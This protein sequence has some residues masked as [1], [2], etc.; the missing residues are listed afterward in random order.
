MSQKLL[1]FMAICGFSCSGF[2]KS[3]LASFDV[4]LFV[5]VET[6]ITPQ[7]SFTDRGFSLNDASLK[8]ERSL[9][10]LKLSVDLPFSSN[11]TNTTDG[12]EF[13]TR[14]AEAYI[15]YKRG[16]YQLK[17]GQY[18][19]FFGYEANSSRERFFADWG[20]VREFALPKTHMG[21]QLEA[22]GASSKVLLQVANPNGN[23]TLGREGPEAGIGWW[24]ERGPL[25][26][27]VGA[28]FHE[29]EASP[30]GNRMNLLTELRAGVKTE[31]FR[32]VASFHLKRSAGFEDTGQALGLLLTYDINESWVTGGRFER[33]REIY[34]VLPMGA[35]VFDAVTS[36]SLGGLYR[37][38]P[39][40]FLRSDF[41]ITAMNAPGID[42][43]FEVFTVSAV[44]SF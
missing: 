30:V 1:L 16:S 34:T 6:R 28:T 21:L 31:R 10:D 40:L 43:V 15:E 27:L 8:A 12:F 42:E 17:L 41:T 36:G 20:P 5:D 19:A 2:G 3:R 37:F 35:G 13:A 38:H 14:R 11:A 23:N 24:G 4:S 26:V 7:R 44:A 33:L 39:A 32:S 22:G 25:H 29:S 9:N 18:P